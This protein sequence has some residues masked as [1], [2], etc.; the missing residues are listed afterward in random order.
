MISYSIKDL[1]SISG[2][3]AHTLRIWE[4]RYELFKPHRTDTNI[5]LYNNDD[6]RKLLNIALLNN[7]G[8]KIS[9]IATLSNSEI[10]TKALEILS[11]EDT[12]QSQIDSLTMAMVEIDEDRFESVVSS[13]ILKFGLEDTITQIIY[14]FLVKVGVLWRTESINPG[15]EHFITNLI[16]QKLIAAI[17]GQVMQITDDSK[18]FLLYL[19]EN[20]LHEISILFYNYLIRKSNYK[21]IYLGQSV[22]FEDVV[23]ICDSMQPTHVISVLTAGIRSKK[24]LEYIGQLSKKCNKQKI[25][26]SGYQVLENENI[27]FEN[28]RIFK[29]KEDLS[30]LIFNH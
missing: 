23:K 19:P 14:P 6:I 26:L 16:R 29:N 5:R 17:D 18:K 4:V 15:Q 24:V 2:I 28:V 25:L 9:K 21:T 1:E 20:E 3:K 12:F 11:T 30:S 22:P 7:H 10:S 27:K 13:S 8:L